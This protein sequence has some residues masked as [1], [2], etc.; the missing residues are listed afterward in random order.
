MR[1][2]VYF[3]SRFLYQPG[4][5]Y[6]NEKKTVAKVVVQIL[7]ELPCKIYPVSAEW[8]DAVSLVG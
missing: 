8:R 2:I 1:I 4:I 3:I 5:I 6:L 7:N